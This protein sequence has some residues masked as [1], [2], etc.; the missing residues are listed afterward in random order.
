MR[1]HVKAN[2]GKIQESLLITG[3]Q[4]FL[5]SLRYIGSMNTMRLLLLAFLAISTSSIA[6]IGTGQWR[7]HI[8]ANRAIDVVATNTTVYTAF[9]NGVTEYDLSSNELS[10][11][12]AVNSLSDITVSCLG[13]STSDNSIFVGYENGNIDKI[14]DNEVTNIPAIKLA[15]IQGS[16]K[17]Y[18]MVEKD[19]YMYLATGFAIVKI[20]PVKN[21][22]RDTYYPTNGNDAIVD[23][24]FRND[25]IY[26]LGDDRMYIGDINNAALADPAQWSEDARV[27]VLMTEKYQDLMVYDN[28]LYMSLKVDGFGGDTLYRITPTTIEVAVNETFAVEINS[29]TIIGDKLVVNY[30][31]GPILYD[32]LLNNFGS[33]YAYTFGTPRPNQTVFTNGKYYIADDQSGLV[34]YTSLSDNKRIAF[35]GPPKNTF[36]QMDWSGGRL[37]VVG[38]GLSQ[39]FV[40]FSKSGLYLFEDEEWELRDDTNQPMWNTN[41]WDYVSVSINPNDKDEIAVGTYSE[42]PLSI[43]DASGQVVDT[44]TPA[45]SELEFTSLGNGWSYVS[46]LQYDN[47][48][49]LWVLNGYSTEPIKV[50][51]SDDQWYSFDLGT[52]AKSK[53]TN[54]LV[55]DYNGNKWVS[56]TNAGLYG[57]NDGGTIS[58]PGDDQVVNLNSGEQSGALPSNEVTAI[59]VDFDNE[60]WIGTDNGFAVLYNSDG[61][62][63]AGPG[64]YNA[65]RIKVEFEGNVEYVLGA[66]H[67]T[68]I[69]VDGANRKWFATANS[70]IILL[71]ADGLEV[72]EHYTTENSPLISNNVL[73]I[74]LDHNTGELYIITDNGLISYRTD[75]TYEDPDYSDVQIFPNPAR[76]D[77]EGPIT[78]QGIRYNSDVKITDVAGNLVYKTTSNGGTATWDGRTLTGEKVATGVYLIW[79]AA[80]EGK[81]RFVGKVLVVN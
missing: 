27:P 61:A 77:F 33:I 13:Q 6:Q 19:G 45:N 37:A 38:G 65:Q 5:Y 81:G 66:T 34:E 35:P 17:I 47:S 43:M 68:D 14:K 48:G 49:N 40:T 71:S 69:E 42:V 23:I 73:D 24:A 79:T 18:K 75:A 54:K 46:G 55:I 16:K 36:Y 1:S 67:I 7:L 8:P 11:W 28:E 62:F 10:I 64:D 58:N 78:I 44:I 29:L 59:A 51:T 70:G 15:E 22:V 32:N 12:D 30:Y 39:V 74:K 26:A 63:G 53:F 2:I 41:I 31:T 9:E 76:P 72:I 80:N 57:L 21:E 20:D 25:T 4:I 50:K 56:I 52:S 60:I 3:N